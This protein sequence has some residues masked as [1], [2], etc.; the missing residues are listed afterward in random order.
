MT[1]VTGG[2][3]DDLIQEFSARRH[4]G[5]WMGDTRPTGTKRE[6]KLRLRG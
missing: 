2:D 1:S 4:H 6:R 5:Q 3:G